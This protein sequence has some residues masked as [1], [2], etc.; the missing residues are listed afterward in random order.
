VLTPCDT[1]I[2]Q[3]SLD[4]LAAKTPAREGARPLLVMD[5]ANWHKAKALD[6]H[7]F[8]PVYLPPY[9]RDLNLIERFR[10][11]LTN[12]FFADDFPRDGFELEERI[13]EGLRSFFANPQIVASQCAIS[14]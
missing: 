12:D 8:E 10:L 14:V 5:N 9:L 4:N 6:F 13:I 2:F 7:H 3:A 11:R 1:E